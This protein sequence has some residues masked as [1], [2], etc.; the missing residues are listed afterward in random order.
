MN[1]SQHMQAQENGFSICI[2]VQFAEAGKCCA[3]ARDECNKYD[4]VLPVFDWPII[5]IGLGGLLLVVPIY[6]QSSLQFYGWGC[7]T[8]NN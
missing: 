6:L 3:P 5:M 8:V 2:F 1:K 4:L 7:K